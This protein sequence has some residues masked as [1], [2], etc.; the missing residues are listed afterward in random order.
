M[1]I[2]SKVPP[3][4]FS[5]LTKF[6]T[7]AF[8]YYQTK[9]L[10]RF[11]D[12]GNAATIWGHEVH[13]AFELRIKDG[14]AFPSWG[15]KWEPLAGQIDRHRDRGATVL[16][17][18]K[19]CITRDFQPTAWDGPDAWARG[20]LDLM[21]ID[22][23]TCVS[24]DWKTGKIKPSKQLEM[25][26]GIIFCHYPEVEVIKTAFFWLKHDK[27]TRDEYTRADIPAIWNDFLPRVRR[28]E[29]AYEKD[30]WPE[31]PSGLCKQW[32]PVKDC[33]FYKEK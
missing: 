25:S 15:T 19:L 22:G 14:T 21:V 33:K 30:K 11:V 10:G 9:V 12:Q 7:C 8:Q 13:T 27:V 2:A 32:C 4:S 1:A 31:K 16:T 20:I 28:L 26:A 23:T 5:S 3:V 17:E 18:E 24:A 6:E 29:L